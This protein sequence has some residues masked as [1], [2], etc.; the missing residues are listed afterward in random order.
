MKNL[1]KIKIVR[2]AP[3]GCALADAAAARKAFP[4]MKA[5]ACVRFAL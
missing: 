3:V 2:R 5:S 4:E 1:V